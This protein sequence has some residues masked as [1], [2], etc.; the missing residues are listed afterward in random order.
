MKERTGKVSGTHGLE[1]LISLKWP[2]HDHDFLD[3]TP[4]T[5]TNKWYYGKP[6]KLLHSTENHQQNEK[7]TYQMGEKYSNHISDKGL[8]SKIYKKLKQLNRKKN[9]FEK[10]TEELNRHFPKEDVQMVNR[11]V[12]RCSTPLP[13]GKGKLKPQ[14]DIIS[15]ILEWLFLKGQVI[16]SVDEDM[17][18][19]EPLCSISRNRKLVHPLWKLLKKFKIELPY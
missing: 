16:I 11:Y 7:A 9:P 19:R 3:F 12:K 6:K 14:W 2:S 17:E 8:I 1:E 5:K 4:K 10:W 13:S 15:H 18:K